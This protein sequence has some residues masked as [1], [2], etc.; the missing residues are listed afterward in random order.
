MVQ[1][2]V[3]I[4]LMLS[5]TLVR[6][7]AIIRGIALRS[8]EAGEMVNSSTSKAMVYKGISKAWSILSSKWCASTDFSGGGA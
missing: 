8:S 3:G 5:V 1:Q 6:K 4:I 2:E 7:Q